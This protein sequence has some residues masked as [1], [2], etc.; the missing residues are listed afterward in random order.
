MSKEF[1]EWLTKN[2]VRSFSPLISVS[3]LEEAKELISALQ[4]EKDKKIV[5][6]GR[7]YAKA[8]MEVANTNGEHCKV[9]VKEFE[10]LI[11]GR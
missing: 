4:K 11:R 5:Q 2:H 10:R 9:V 7:N 8:L 6:E 3:L 1:A